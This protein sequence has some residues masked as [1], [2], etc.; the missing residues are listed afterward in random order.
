MPVEKLNKYLKRLRKRF[1]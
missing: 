1:Y